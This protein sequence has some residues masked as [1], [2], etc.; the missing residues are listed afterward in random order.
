MATNI[1]CILFGLIPHDGSNEHSF[2]M[3]C[4][5]VAGE[6]GNNSIFIHDFISLYLLGIVSLYSNSL[7]L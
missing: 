4:L 1:H 2:A 5:T 6:G 3:D 7:L